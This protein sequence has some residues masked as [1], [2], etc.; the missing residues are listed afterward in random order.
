MAASSVI[1][2]SCPENW[3]T[4]GRTIRDRCEFLFNKDILS[5]VKF[6]I[7]VAS[8][9]SESKKSKQVISAHKFV[10]S[11]SSPVFYT[12]FYGELP[13]TRDFV[14][15][16]DC[17]YDSLLEFF[18]YIYS[19]KVN[20][21]GNNVMQLLYLSKK[22]MV[23][24]LADECTEFLKSQL[25]P[26][27]VFSVLPIAELHK[28]EKLAEHCWML[29]DRQSKV[30]LESDEFET[31][32]RSLLQAVVERDSLNITE[33]KLFDAVDRW[34]TKECEKQGLPTEGQVKRRVLGEQIIKAIRFP[35]MGQTE[36]TS[37]VANRGILTEE[38]TGILDQYFNSTLNQPVG[39]SDAKRSS[40]SRVEGTLLRCRRFRDYD[41][42]GTW[43]YNGQTDS[44]LF[45]VDRIV[46]LHGVCFFGMDSKDYSVSLELEEVKNKKGHSVLK[47]SGNFTSEPQLDGYEGFEFFFDTPV[48]LNSA[49]D[50]KYR[51]KALISGPRSRRGATRYPST[52]CAGVRF[53]FLKDDAN[54]ETNGTNAFR[55]Q[56]PEF[57]FTRHVD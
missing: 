43:T 50:T 10:L 35:V 28:E 25:Y 7:Q 13:E 12:M 32:D 45:E 2:E 24:S 16:P 15:L 20:L 46:S 47:Q 11:I 1:P 41:N 23:P 56:F 55:G 9:I 30:A 8:D 29:I 54:I 53:T 31:I 49:E 34:A 17:G 26:S 57:L 3:Q 14:E 42:S 4:T 22:Y 52:G 39:F 44:I 5:D 51:L 19:D 33:V 40:S 6:V 18:R 48:E 36:F 38:E 37:V 21:N 27:N